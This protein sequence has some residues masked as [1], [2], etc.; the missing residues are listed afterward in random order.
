M[1]FLNFSKGLDFWH[2]DWH[3]MA[4][5]LWSQ[6]LSDSVIVTVWCEFHSHSSGTQS[7]YSA[8]T[9]ICMIDNVKY[10]FCSSI[11]Q[12]VYVKGFGV[13]VS[14]C[15][16]TVQELSEHSQVHLSVM[17]IISEI[18]PAH[19]I[20]IQA[21]YVKNAKQFIAE[22]VENF[23]VSAFKCSLLKFILALEVI[24]GVAIDSIM[25]DQARHSLAMSQVCFHKFIG[26]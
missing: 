4:Q 7:T 25:L 5:K 16:M 11:M 22:T 8:R 3:R 1:N 10:H 14:A 20:R 26:V 19:R 13:C 6:W 17:L 2:S 12:R 18:M 21:C 15:N 9:M 23:D 24:C